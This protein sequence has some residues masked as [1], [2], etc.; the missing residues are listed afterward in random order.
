MRTKPHGFALV[1]LVVVCAILAPVL[2]VLLSA[3][4]SVSDALDVNQRDADV[5][6]KTRAA[7]VSAIAL[8]RPASLVSLRAR[9]GS[10]WVVPVDTT[11]Y[12][13][14]RFQEP[15]ALPN[16]DAPALTAPRMLELVR[17][18]RELV[19]GLDDDA[20]GLVDEG[21]L[22]LTERDGSRAC[23][24]SGVT[25]LTFVK[26]GRTLEVSLQCAALDV[27]RHAHMQRCTQVVSL[28]NN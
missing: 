8:V 1:E 10:A 5:A 28:R 12:S 25:G 23:L 4:T 27:K 13:A 21:S 7:I 3:R 24:T 11:E 18:E 9:Q 26:S 6:Q 16:G 19:N 15:A 2:Y 17:D 20:D 14:L 22:W